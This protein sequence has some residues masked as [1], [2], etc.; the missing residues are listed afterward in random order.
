MAESICFPDVVKEEIDQI[1]KLGD[2]IHTLAQIQHDFEEKTLEV[3]TEMLF[4]WAL[5]C[6]HVAL[7]V[8]E[9]LDA[10]AHGEAESPKA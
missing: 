6:H 5:V 10:A 8:P 9:K 4:A 7:W 2:C 1:K 3:S